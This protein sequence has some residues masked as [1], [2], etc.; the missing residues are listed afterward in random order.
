MWVLCVGL[1]FTSRESLIVHSRFSCVLWGV[2]V[3]RVV[4]RCARACVCGC[5][6]LFNKKSRYWGELSCVCVCVC[7]CVYVKERGE[8]GQ[9]SVSPI[10]VLSSSSAVPGTMGATPVLSLLSLSLSLSL[11]LTHTHTSLSFFSCIISLPL[12][13][14]F[15][16]LPSPN[17]HV[18][19]CRVTR[20][21]LPVLPLPTGTLG[22]GVQPSDFSARAVSHH[23]VH[24]LVTPS[25]IR[26]NPP[27]LQDG[28]SRSRP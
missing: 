19:S 14:R 26:A 1:A 17:R 15:S 18:S 4:S 11:S 5:T 27:H 25:V 7:V 3:C 16:V 20:E 13:S 22:G 24:T 9:S 8:N 21:Y 28:R 10:W 6:P 23:R 2:C 12:C